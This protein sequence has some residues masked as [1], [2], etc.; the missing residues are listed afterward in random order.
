RDGHHPR[1]DRRRMEGDGVDAS[2]PEDR[3]VDA[4]LR[5]ARLR[6]RRGDGPLS[7]PGRV[8]KRGPRAACGCA[9]TPG[10]HGVHIAL[11]QSEAVP[12]NATAPGPG[13]SPAASTVASNVGRMLNTLTSVAA[14]EP[15]ARLEELP[16]AM[17]VRF[18]PPL[19]PKAPLLRCSQLSNSPLHADP[20]AMPFSQ[21]CCAVAG[22]VPAK[23]PVLSTS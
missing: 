21:H 3:C 20:T 19:G 8:L 2:S 11:K 22:V 5:G 4:R 14:P 6:G 7:R 1:A 18:A 13:R 9:G 17:M 15:L 23:A 10:N 16:I 12:G